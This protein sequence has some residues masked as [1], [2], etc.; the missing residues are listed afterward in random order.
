MHWTT[1]LLSFRRRFNSKILLTVAVLALPLASPLQAQITNIL[2]FEDFESPL[3]T[4]ELVPAAPFFEGGVGDIQ[5]TV[6]GGVVEFSGTVSQQWWAGATLRVVPTFT[7]S[8]A[9]Q[10]AVEVDR[11]AEAGQG[12]ASRSAL[13]VMDSTQTYYVL[14][15]DVRG[16][17]G[18]RYN[19]KIGVAGDNPTGGGTEYTPWN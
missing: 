4:N 18:W 6:T 1:R 8:D 17:A 12:T 5:G 14:F 16:E 10:V 13:W 2:F 19:R 9:N 3:N 11:V 15:A 7:V